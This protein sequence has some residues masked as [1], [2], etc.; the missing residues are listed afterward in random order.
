[1]VMPSSKVSGK[2]LPANLD[3]KGYGGISRS[4]ARSI[5]TGQ[6]GYTSRIDLHGCGRDEAH[7]RLK[8]FIAASVNNGHR[9]VLIITGKGMGGKG[10]IRSHLPIWLDEPPLSSHV[11]AYCQAQPKDGGAGAWYV[12]LRRR[13]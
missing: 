5:K 13:S 9:H 6:A 12:N 11:I 2:I 3:E 1:A 8:A 4:G 10:V 7:Q